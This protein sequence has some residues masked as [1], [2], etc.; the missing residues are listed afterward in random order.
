MAL[1]CFSNTRFTGRLD[2]ELHLPALLLDDPEA[3]ASLPGVSLLLE[4]DGRRILRLLVSYRGRPSPCYLYCYRKHSWNHRF[5][6]PSAFHILTKS[7]E[8][9]AAGIPT[10]QVWGAFRPRR[11]LLNGRS[12]LIAAEIEGVEELPSTG[13]HVYQLHRWARL[14][15]QLLSALAEAVARLHN[16]GFT[17]GDLKARHVLVRRA[18][19]GHPPTLYFVDLE[20]T[21]RLSF[22]PPVVADAFAARDWTQLSASLAWPADPRDPTGRR[23]ARALVEDYLGYRRLTDRR[24]RRIRSFVRLYSQSFRQGVP[25]LRNLLQVVLTRGKPTTTTEATLILDPVGRGN[26]TT[27]AHPV[28]VSDTAPGMEPS[29]ARTLDRY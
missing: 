26:Q 10:L 12:Y 2:T 3:A 7:L 11:Q 6:R 14:D 1:K 5:R 15:R 29:S 17:H 25:L 20:K 24:R 23:Q 8:L 27:A 9:Q 18:P 22:V 21:R 28:R 13:R 19:A 4:C 16:A